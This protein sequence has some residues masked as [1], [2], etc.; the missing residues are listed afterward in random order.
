MRQDAQMPPPLGSRPFAG[1]W[2]ANEWLV[3]NAN[4][5]IYSNLSRA[6]RA[7]EI[8]GTAGGGPGRKS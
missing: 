6:P 7:V 4:L 3:Y 1:P 5:L 8:R 2:P